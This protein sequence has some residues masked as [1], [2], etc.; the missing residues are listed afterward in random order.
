MGKGITE[1]LRIIKINNWTKRIQDRA[2]WKKVVGK[3][4]TIKQ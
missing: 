3:A 1:V 2:K 4:I